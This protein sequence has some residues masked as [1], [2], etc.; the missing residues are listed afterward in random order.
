MVGAGPELIEE[1][2]TPA[3]TTGDLAKALGRLLDAVAHPG[4]VASSVGALVGAGAVDG[5][6][7]VAAGSDVRAGEGE[8]VGVGGGTVALGVDPLGEH[9]AGDNRHEQET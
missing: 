5:T 3:S 8:G 9:T 1:R 4:L 6:I 2:L 7:E